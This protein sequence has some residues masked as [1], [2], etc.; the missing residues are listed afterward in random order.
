MEYLG[1]QRLPKTCWT[2]YTFVD[3]P[4]E[5]YQYILTKEMYFRQ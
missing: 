1:C 4:V 3:E 2:K 5:C